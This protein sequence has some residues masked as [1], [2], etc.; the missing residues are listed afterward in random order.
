MEKKEIIKES[1]H[2]VVFNESF[3]STLTSKIVTEMEK[4]FVDKLVAYENEISKL[5]MENNSLKLKCDD[6][7]QR[8]RGNNIRIHGVPTVPADNVERCLLEIFRNEMKIDVHPS[9]IDRCHHVGPAMN[10]KQSIIIKFSNHKVRWRALTQRKNLRGSNISVVE[11]LTSHRHNLFTLAKKKI[12]H[13]DVWIS[14]GI[15]YIRRD[16]V[17]HRISDH[18][19]LDRFPVV[20][21]TG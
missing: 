3:L 9:D 4:L 12:G 17:R 15:V 1:V 7:E 13:R 14:N 21:T 10:G 5:K 8:S 2:E 11:D 6:L 19:D 18:C 20:S 16:G